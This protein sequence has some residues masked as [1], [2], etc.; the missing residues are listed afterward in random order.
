MILSKIYSNNSKMKPI[1]FDSGLNI[2]FGDVVRG[3]DENG[4]FHEHNLGKTALVYLID[5]L[6]LKK[7]SEFFK[8]NNVEFRNWTFFL[9]I[10]L[11]NGKYLTIRRSVNISSRVSFKLHEEKN[12]NFTNIGM[13]SWDYTEVSINTKSSRENAVKILESYLNFNKL[14]DYNYRHFL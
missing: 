10:K 5:F 1:L 4:K 14:Q 9:E 2:I 8:K 12:Q 7:Q 3:V 13:D 6:L 11:N